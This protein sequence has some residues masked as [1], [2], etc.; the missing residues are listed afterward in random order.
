MTDQPLRDKPR[1]RP[2]RLVIWLVK[3]T[4]DHIRGLFTITRIDP[5]L[6][7]LRGVDYSFVRVDLGVG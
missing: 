7:H 1:L 3:P 6:V 5:G 4:V 2:S